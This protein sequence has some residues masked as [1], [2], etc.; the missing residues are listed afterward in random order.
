M[1]SDNFHLIVQHKDGYW[2]L[3]ETQSM[4]RWQEKQAK[5]DYRRARKLAKKNKA[6]EYDTLDAALD[7][8]NEVG[9]TEYGEVVINYED[10]YD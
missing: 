7:A 1:S 10:Y 9:Y 2:L 5:E 3:V 4:T 8:S 6:K